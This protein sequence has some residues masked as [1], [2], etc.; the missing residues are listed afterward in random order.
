VIP[1]EV[2]Q[3]V[4]RSYGVNPDD[5]RFVLCTLIPLSLGGS[6]RSSN[7]FPTTRWFAKLKVRVDAAL[8]AQVKSGGLTPQAARAQLQSDW[9]KAAHSNYVRNYGQRNPVKAKAL[10]DRLAW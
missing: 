3:A 10:E 4:F 2:R 8:T 7:L 6:E 1:S 9:I 5:S